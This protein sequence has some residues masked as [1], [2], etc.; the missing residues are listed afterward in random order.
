[1]ANGNGNG[2]PFNGEGSK[3]TRQL[4]VEQASSGIFEKVQELTDAGHGPTLEETLEH[5]K[6]LFNQ[7]ET[8]FFQHQGKVIDKRTVLCI[9]A[10][11]AGIRFAM[12]IHNLTGRLKIEHSGQ[13]GV[14]HSAKPEPRDRSKLKN[15]IK[16]ITKKK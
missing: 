7:R 5:I 9:P 2:K 1:M 4:A 14:E 11:I 16:R 12:E 3:S 8:K 6:I 10:R 15:A 13:V